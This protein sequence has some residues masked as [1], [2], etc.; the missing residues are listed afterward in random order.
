[1]SLRDKLGE[2]VPLLARKPALPREQS[3]ALKPTR[4]PS[5]QWEGAPPDEDSPRSGG[6]VLKVPVKPG[7][8]SRIL[9]RVFSMPA[10]K[11]IELDEFGGE[12]WALCDGQHT[13]EQFVQHTVRKYQLNRRQAEVSVLAFMRMLLERRLVGFREADLPT[14]RKGESYGSNDHHAR[15]IGRKRRQRAHRRH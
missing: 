3:L 1:M 12:V 2:Y 7:G 15:A 5:V 9:T 11:T 13:V 10:S 14:A 8:I 4:N 6:V